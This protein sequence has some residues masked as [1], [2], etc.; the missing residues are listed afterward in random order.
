MDGANRRVRVNAAELLMGVEVEPG[1]A[2]GI[3]R[4]WREIPLHAASRCQV[5]LVLSG[6]WALAKTWVTTDPATP[7]QTGKNQFIGQLRELSRM[8]LETSS[9]RPYLAGTLS[10]W[11]CGAAATAGS[12]SRP[13]APGSSPACCLAIKT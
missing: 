2:A 3:S 6:L 7:W 8:E 12:N 9:R 13:M 5:A 11:G 10:A 4:I 1:K